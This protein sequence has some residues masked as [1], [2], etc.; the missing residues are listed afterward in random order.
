MNFLVHGERVKTSKKHEVKLRR[1]FN[2]TFAM[3]EKCQKNENVQT[4][5]ICANLEQ[6]PNIVDFFKKFN[7]I[8]DGSYG[9]KD[10]FFNI[11]VDKLQ[12]TLGFLEG[13]GFKT[14]RKE[15]KGNICFEA[16]TQVM[17]ID[18]FLCHCVLY[19]YDSFVLRGKN[20]SILGTAKENSYINISYLLKEE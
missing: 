13:I 14:T 16:I 11:V 7:V 20:Y 9:N 5:Y 18:G 3:I 10:V 19:V 1:V 6:L 17:D 2:Q 4:S 8:F 12:I 15:I